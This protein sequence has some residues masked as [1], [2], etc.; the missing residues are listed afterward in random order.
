M[1]STRDLKRSRIGGLI[2]RWAGTILILFIAVL[3]ACALLWHTIGLHAYV[4][5]FGAAIATFLSPLPGLL[6]P[7]A[8]GKWLVAIIVSPLVGLATWYATH[9]LEESQANLLEERSKLALDKANLT[10]RLQQDNVAVAAVLTDLAPTTR[11]ETFVV[12]ARKLHDLFGRKQFSSVID[13]ADAMLAADP[14]NGHGLYFAG[15]AY[16]VTGDRTDMRGAFQ[17]YFAA[18]DHDPDARTGDAAACSARPRGFCAERSAWIGH[19]MANDYFAE[20]KGE[21]GSMKIDDLRNA[22]VYERK[23][24]SFR[25][26]EFLHDQWAHSSCELLEELARQLEALGESAEGARDLLDSQCKPQ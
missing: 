18:A 17:H 15:E 23:S 9:D 14:D 24:F 20:A 4:A 19:L 12:I 22:I 10:G 25:S 6:S 3:A 26:A 13:I 21:D 11:K 16:R 5:A 2:G 1:T 7:E 8:R